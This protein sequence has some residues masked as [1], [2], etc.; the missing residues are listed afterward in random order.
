VGPPESSSGDRSPVAGPTVRTAREARPASAWAPLRLHPV[1]RA[2]WIAQFASNVG[3]WMQT[4][5]AQWLLVDRSPLLVS[6]VQTAASLPLVLLALPAGAWADLVDRRRLLLGAQLAMFLAAAALAGATFLDAATPTVILTLTFALGC[7]NAVA[8]PVWQA[9][10][11]DLVD[12]A[13]LPQA[14]ALNGLNMNVARA[15][16]PAIGGF[17]VAAL[18]AGWVFALNAV[19]FV[20]IATVVANWRAPAR[21][22]AGPRERLVEALLAGGRYV[23]HALIVRRLLYRAVLFIPAASAV[24]ALLPV[25]A[26]TNL[27][28]GSAGYG[29]LLAMVGAGAV[30]GAV[31]I[32]RL[33]A[34]V[35][36]ARLVTGAMVATAAA[37]AVVATVD[38]AVL[39]G[40]AL[41]PIGGAWIAVMSSLNSGLQLALPNWVR[42][43]GLA[44][45]LVVF[46]G[47]QA[48]G[49][50]I[51]GA[52]ADGTSVTTALLAAAAV[53]VLGAAVGLR[54]PMPD[55]SRLDRTPS[56]HWPA[57]QVMF[58]PDAA[59]GPV[60]VTLT[61]RVP[62]ENSGVFTDA[63]RHVGRSRRRTGALRWE[64]FRDGSDPTRFVE[65]YLVGTWA[66]HLRQHGN[67]L[68][69][70]DR[71]FEEQARRYTLGEP[72]VAHLF[73]PPSDQPTRR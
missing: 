43:R 18:G 31:V 37:I 46:Q 73:P 11:P 2:L 60:L 25:V 45:Y 72:Q 8:S 22:D 17:V 32:P 10:Q 12:R 35:G 67:R 55:T 48:I 16:G 13:L 24:W 26:A 33:R 29:L 5:G 65:S 59:D 61:Y 3:T 14:A 19:S 27:D 54:S 20:G 34:R 4:I 9:I 63:M 49:A 53:L 71:R 30:A 50:V 44:Y 36:S 51:W 6:L 7:G 69:G 39:V 66:E 52:A 58:T 40:I 21:A 28:L 42:A 47:S 1:F 62:E 41:V 68:T 57:P 23:R 56:A 15:V 38:N 70:A 64:L